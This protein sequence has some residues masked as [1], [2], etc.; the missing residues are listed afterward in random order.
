MQLSSWFC[1]QRARHRRAL[2]AIAALV[3]GYLLTELSLRFAFGDRLRSGTQPAIYVSDDTYGYRYL[4]D[5][6]STLCIPGIC[7]PVRVNAAGLLGPHA[8]K[9][10]TP[11]TYRIAFVGS[12]EATGIWMD[13][14]RAHPEHLERLL[15]QDGFDVEVYNFSTDGLFLDYERALLARDVVPEFAPD[16]VVL[17][18]NFLPFVQTNQRREMYRGYVLGWGADIPGAHEDARQQVDFIESHTWFIGWY[19]RSY[20]PRALL[21]WSANHLTDWRRPYLRAFGQKRW[22]GQARPTPLSTKAS[23]AL[24]LETQAQL[25]RQGAALVQFGSLIHPTAIAKGLRYVDIRFPDDPK[26]KNRFDGHMNERG[27]LVVAEQ[28]HAAL[29]P[30]L[31]A[32]EAVNEAEHGRPAPTPRADARQLA[33]HGSDR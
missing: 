19:E 8:A 11:D 17:E 29:R 3:L 6:T 9:E 16:L 7:R 27:Q 15:R 24:L 31:V 18:T 2:G 26:F 23:L 14:G 12:C 10:R 25:A 5:A 21:R 30:Y 4:P 32:H 20:V 28:L 1:R 13:S 33:E 22:S